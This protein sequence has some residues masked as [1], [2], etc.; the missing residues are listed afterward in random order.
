MSFKDI[1]AWFG[2]RGIQLESHF[3]K[4]IDHDEENIYWIPNRDVELE[5]WEE[6]DGSFFASDI[7]TSD[8]TVAWCPI[9]SIC[10]ELEDEVTLD[11]SPFNFGRKK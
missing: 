4:K 10:A 2:N 11:K 8:D 3:V 7:C 1:Q 6:D 5:E 9:W